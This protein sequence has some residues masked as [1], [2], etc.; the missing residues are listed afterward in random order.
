MLYTDPL[1]YRVA[2]SYMYD[3]TR[4]VLVLTNPM[5]AMSNTVSFLYSAYSAVLKFTPI[6]GDKPGETKRWSEFQASFRNADAC[7]EAAV[8]FATNILQSSS[9]INWNARVG[10][11]GKT[12]SFNAWGHSPWGQFA[13][14]EGVTIAREYTT[15]PCITLRTLVPRDAAV[16][17][18]VQPILT[19]VAAGEPF[20]LQ[21]ITFTVDKGSHRTTR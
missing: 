16:G 8:S 5:K 3:S 15:T 4:F 13:W 10:T 9:Q 20:S 18:Y 17:T 14:S 21:S 12:I 1:I 11:D 7:S 6:H 19:H 2:E